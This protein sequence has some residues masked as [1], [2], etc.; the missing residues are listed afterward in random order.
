MTHT[1]L[2]LILHMIS[3]LSFHFIWCSSTSITE[4]EGKDIFGDFSSSVM[5]LFP[6]QVLKHWYLLDK[7]IKNSLTL[8]F[9]CK[10]IILIPLKN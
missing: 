2:T 8:K 5:V 6:C 4:I 9:I 3:I 1:I 10:E 7:R